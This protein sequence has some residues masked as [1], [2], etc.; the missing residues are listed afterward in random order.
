LPTEPTRKDYTFQNWNT[1]ANGSGSAFT[2]S[3]AVTE[4]I[5]VYAQWKLVGTK[6]TI[7]FDTDGDVT[8]DAVSA[9]PTSAEAG[10]TITI[11]YTLAGGYLNNRLV[12]SGV[13][14]AITEVNEAGTGTRTYTVDAEDAD[15]DGKITIDAIFTHTNKEIDTIAFEHN[16]VQKTYGDAVFTV[17]ASAGQGSGA[18]TYSS[19]HPDIATVNTTTGEVTIL[20]AGSTTIKATKA[21]DETYEEAIAEYTLTISKAAGATLTGP[22]TTVQITTDTIEVTA[23]TAPGNGQTVEYAIVTTNNEP[24][25]NWQDETTFTELYEGTTYYIFARAAGN[26]NY[27]A[28]AAISG[29]FSTTAPPATAVTSWNFLT[30]EPPIEPSPYVNTAHLPGKVRFETTRPGN[31]T[32]TWASGQGLTV[33]YDTNYH[34]KLLIIPFVLPSGKSLN[35]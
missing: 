14:A 15:Q 10:D 21:A 8:G 19:S 24:E 6:Y 28:G 32:I 11:N 7:A 23:V 18:V 25:S 33:V 34:S 16:T 9:S 35:D 13:E 1:A 31:A 2:E 29:S 20:K 22:L 3:T 26:D 17:T 30:T 4:N 12:F 5:T 27:A